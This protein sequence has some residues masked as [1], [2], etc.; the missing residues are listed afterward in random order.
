[1]KEYINRSEHDTRT[2]QAP[3]GKNNTSMQGEGTSIRQEQVESNLGD[4]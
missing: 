2:S 3:H 1:M 4:H